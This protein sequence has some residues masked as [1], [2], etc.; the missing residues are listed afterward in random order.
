MRADLGLVLADPV[1][2]AGDGA[3]AD[4][5]ALADMRVAEIGQVADL[6]ALIQDGVLDLDEVADMDI[7]AQFGAGR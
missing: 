3:G 1:V 4:I 5:R 7:R 6:D 2:I